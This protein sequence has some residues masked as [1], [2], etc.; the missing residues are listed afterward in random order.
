MFLAFFQTAISEPG[1]IDLV[2]TGG[3]LTIMTAFVWVTNRVVGPIVKAAE[4]FT[5]NLEEASDHRYEEEKHWRTC[6]AHQEREEALLS[7]I[8]GHFML[9]ADE[10]RH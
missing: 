8:A 9:Q 5:K 6:E 2:G 3:Q 10:A 7:Q 1:A 4:A